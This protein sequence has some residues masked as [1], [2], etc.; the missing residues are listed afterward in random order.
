MLLR[1]CFSKTIPKA[2]SPFYLIDN[3]DLPVII[4]CIEHTTEAYC[5]CIDVDFPF[6]SLQVSDVFSVFRFIV[7]KPISLTGSKAHSATL[8]IQT[9]LRWC[10][11]EHASIQTRNIYSSFCFMRFQSRRKRSARN[12]NIG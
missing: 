8:P 6:T 1:T 2:S 9:Y 3:I 4:W 7:L 10:V 12:W 5:A 11:W